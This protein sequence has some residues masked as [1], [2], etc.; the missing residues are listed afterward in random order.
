VIVGEAVRLRERIAWR[1]R[2]PLGGR[3]VL[4]ARARPGDSLIAKELRGLGA[5]VIEEPTVEAVA[6]SDPMAFVAALERVW[7]Y[8]AVLFSCELGVERTLEVLQGRAGA[9]AALRR[10]AVLA[11]GPATIEALRRGGLTPRA[12]ARGACKEELAPLAPRLR[13]GPVLA[14][15]AENGRPALFEELA[16]LGATG[17][18]PVAA[19]RLVHRFGPRPDRPPDLVVLPSSSAAEAVL[20]SALKDILEDVPMIAMGPRTEEAACQAG[21]R[22]VQRSRRDSVP[23][24][25]AAALAFLA[26]AASHGIRETSVVPRPVHAG[27]T[28]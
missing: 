5:D 15:T 3:R 17:L 19:Y 28:T 11:V 7:R 23:S 2:R 1:E 14:V 21:A 6:P 25:V 13:L 18:E 24:I 26:P 4:V 12:E 22:H 8:G 27:G 20:A 10:A 16:A 9:A